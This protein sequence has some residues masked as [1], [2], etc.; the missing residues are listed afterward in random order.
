MVLAE[1]SLLVSTC[2]PPLLSNSESGGS[3]ALSSVDAVPAA[4]AFC[5][6]LRHTS[7]PASSAAAAPPAGTNGL[8]SKL[9]KKEGSGGGGGGGAGFFLGC[10]V[11]LGASLS[12]VGA[13]CMSAWGGTSVVL[14]GSA[15]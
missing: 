2:W 13:A 11:G 14:F 10:G 5:L 6:R 15:G 7:K 12:A 8:E 1:P 3:C 4:A 9:S